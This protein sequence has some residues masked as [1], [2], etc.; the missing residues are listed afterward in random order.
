[1]EIDPIGG[2]FYPSSVLLLVMSKRSDALVKEHSSH[3]GG[4]WFD[5]SMV[6][7]KCEMVCCQRSNRLM[8]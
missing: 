8:I 3:I 4:N 6:A 7:G 2:R 1:M 5:G